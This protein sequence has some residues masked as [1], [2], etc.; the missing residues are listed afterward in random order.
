MEWADFRGKIAV[1]PAAS[2]ELNSEEIY[3]IA[4]HEIGHLLGLKHNPNPHSVMYFLNV[5]GT[6]VLDS[7]DLLDLSRRHEI[8]R[9]I[10][11]RG[12]LPIQAGGF[13]PAEKWHRDS[14]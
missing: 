2:Q 11:A 8:K 3:G 12:F 4:V 14:A 7:K 1:S 10:F 9:E 13:D 6:E 5:E